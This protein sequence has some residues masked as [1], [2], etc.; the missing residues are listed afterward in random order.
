MKEQQPLEELMAEMG[1]KYG[2]RHDIAY[3]IGMVMQVLGLGI[4]SVLYPIQHPLYT[5]GVMLFEAGVLV[6][7]IFLLVWIT[8][9]KRLILG[10]ILT[11]FAVQLAGMFAP[12]QYVVMILLTGIGLVCVGAAGLAGKEAYC[13]GWREGWIL[14]WS[15]PVVI[16]FNMAAHENR[17]INSLAFSGMFI[18]HLLLSGRKLRQQPLAPCPSNV[19]EPQRHK[20]T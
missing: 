12:E 13:F 4:L 1:I 9:L 17:I 2:K 11:G 14:M 18:L 8:W 10:C 15:Y 16:L 7:G 19:C 20:D 5:T 6:S 3:R